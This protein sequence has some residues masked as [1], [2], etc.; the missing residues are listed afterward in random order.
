MLL[1]RI[2]E[3]PKGGWKA[4]YGLVY[5]YGIL[6]E[7]RLLVPKGKLSVNDKNFTLSNQSEYVRFGQNP[8]P[9]Y[10]CVRHEIS[11][12]NAGARKREEVP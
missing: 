9:M 11:N 8:L 1:A 5:I 7:S 2:I 3:K 12:V 6:L 4:G 10:T